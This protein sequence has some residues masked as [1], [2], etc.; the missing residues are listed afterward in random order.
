M[1]TVENS[2]LTPKVSDGLKDLLLEHTSTFVKDS[3]DFGFCDILQHDIDT[4]DARPIKQSPRRPPLAASAAED[5]ILD[6]G[7]KEPSCSPWASPVCLVKK[8][9]G[10]YRFW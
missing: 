4:G 9:E 8:K 1:Q 2:S 7:V 10:T 6:P 3:A 5:Q